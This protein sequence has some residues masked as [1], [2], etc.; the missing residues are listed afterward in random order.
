VVLVWGLREEEQQS[1]YKDLRDKTDFDEVITSVEAL[2]KAQA[3]SFGKR[4]DEDD[5]GVMETGPLKAVMKKVVK[6]GEKTEKGEERAAKGRSAGSGGKSNDSNDNTESGVKPIFKFIP[7]RLAK[8]C[9][10]CVEEG[11]HQASC[12]YSDDTIAR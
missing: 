12:S 7:D 6:G 1:I 10:R 9:M 5:R 2:A 3:T 11:D 4:K 8:R